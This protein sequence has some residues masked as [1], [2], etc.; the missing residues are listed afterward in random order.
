MA[1]DESAEVKLWRRTSAGLV[2]GLAM[3]WSKLGDKDADI[4]KINAQTTQIAIQTNAAAQQNAANALEVARLKD[5]LWEQS[6]YYELLKDS[7][8]KYRAAYPYPVK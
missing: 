3:L 4:A 1:N 5:K 7:L 6:N 8:R 2:V